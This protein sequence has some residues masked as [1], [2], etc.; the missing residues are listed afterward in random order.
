MVIEKDFLILSTVE[1][2]SLEATVY[3]M[4]CVLMSSAFALLES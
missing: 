1:L 2:Y 3:P 4:V